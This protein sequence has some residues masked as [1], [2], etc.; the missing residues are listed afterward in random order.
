[1]PRRMGLFVLKSFHKQ[2]LDFGFQITVGSAGVDLVV[3]ALKFRKSLDKSPHLSIY[4][5]NLN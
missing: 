3:L 4:Y 5:N 1:M 2:Q